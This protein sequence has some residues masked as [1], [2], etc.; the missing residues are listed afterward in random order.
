MMSR[1]VTLVLILLYAASGTAGDVLLSHGMKHTAV[2]FVLVAVCFFA[3]AYGVF[4]GL[5]RQL[6]CSLVVP[7]QA[8]T[9]GVTVAASHLLLHETVPVLRWTGTLL[10]CAGVAI[11]VLSGGKAPGTAD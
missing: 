7:A 1:A 11:V 2:P 3:L 8:S 6:P 9:Y 4:L 10:V 5:L